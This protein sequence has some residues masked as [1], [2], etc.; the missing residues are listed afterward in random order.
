M[1]V[2]PDAAG[3]VQR[4]VPPLSMGIP[5]AIIVVAAL[6]IPLATAHALGFTPQQTGSWLFALYA[7]PG[8]LS[9]VLTRLYRQPLF[10]SWNGFAVAFFASL[11]GD[12]GYTDLLGAVLVGGAIVALLGA[13]GL[14]ARVAAFVPAPIVFALVAASVLPFVAG[15]FTALGEAP[16]VVGGT[17]LAYVLGR[18]FLGSRIPPILPALVAGLILTG[19]TGRYGTLPEAWTAPP[20]A[21]T[22]PTF[23]LEAL[24][25]VV[26]V[27]VAL[28]ALQANLT[29]TVYLRSQG[30]EPP[31]RLINVAGGLGS[32]LGAGLGPVPVCLSPVLATLTASPDAGER[33]VRH[34]SVYAVG[35]VMVVIALGAGIAAQLPSLLSLSLLLAVAGLALVGVLAQ[36]LSEMVRGP[37]LLGP[38]LTFAVASSQLTLFGLGPLFWAL[39]IGT[40]ISLALEAKALQKLRATKIGDTGE[41]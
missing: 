29:A 14:T 1:V 18:R 37:L 41:E 36:A 4:L 21:L 28:I 9:L 30:Y 13:F 16:V 39:V 15:V 3:R 20:L 6:A 40:G 7:I 34:W 19:V 12:V 24:L 2:A 11:A 8:V 25:T 10:L 35:T 26:P 31:A 27:F 5:L 22:R 32:M 17:L 23:D 38:L 33:E